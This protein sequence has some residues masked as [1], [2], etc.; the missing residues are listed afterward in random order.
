MP[1]ERGYWVALIDT[2]MN[3]FS[4]IYWVESV[5]AVFGPYQ[6]HWYKVCQNFPEY[7][8]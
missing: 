2:F 7:K 1:H 6:N 8:N 4:N 3:R 5:S